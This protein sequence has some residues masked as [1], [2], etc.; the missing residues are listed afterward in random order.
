MA[1][2]RREMTENGVEPRQIFAYDGAAKKNA[3]DIELVIDALDIAYS[4]PGI[5]TFAVVTRDGWFS[6]LGRKLHELGKAVVACADDDCSK[7]LRA[8]ADAFVSLPAPDEGLL[9]AETRPERPSWSR[10]STSA[11]T[12]TTCSTRR[13]RRSCGRSP[14]WPRRIASV[15]SAT[16]FCCRRPAFTSPERSRT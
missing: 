9:V 3:A 10:P 2:L 7:A 8:V 13:V 12:A 16:A 4:R 5:N 14:R 6:A 15:W 1:T 11:L